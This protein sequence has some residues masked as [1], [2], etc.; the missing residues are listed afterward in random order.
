MR[1]KVLEALVG[2]CVWEGQGEAKQ[3]N[4]PQGSQGADR[5]TKGQVAGR[6]APMPPKTPG[7]LAEPQ[8]GCR[9]LGSASG[10][11]EGLRG[12]GEAAA[13]RQ[14]V[15]S[16]AGLWGLGGVGLGASQ[17]APL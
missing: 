12:G 5:P 13:T 10:R 8:Q 15:T 16:R 11:G 3:R 14:G 2:R 7:N 6:W 17:P 1:G 4:G 9:P